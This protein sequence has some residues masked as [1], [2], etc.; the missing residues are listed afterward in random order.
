MELIGGIADHVVEVVLNHLS[1]TDTLREAATNANTEKNTG[2]VLN[3][4]V[5]AV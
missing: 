2:I 1:K 5:G 3:V 4:G